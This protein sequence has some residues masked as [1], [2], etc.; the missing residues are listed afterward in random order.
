[1]Y[2][3]KSYEISLLKKKKTQRRAQRDNMFLNEALGM[4][5]WSGWGSQETSRLRCWISILRL[6]R[7]FIE[8]WVDNK[9]EGTF[10]GD[11]IMITVRSEMWNQ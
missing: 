5:C 1:M 10:L 11:Q 7:I 8:F 2:T 3:L 9:I 4:S 6:S